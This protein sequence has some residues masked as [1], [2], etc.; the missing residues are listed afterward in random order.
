MIPSSSIS[1]EEAEGKAA[2]EAVKWAKALQLQ[3]VHFE[4]DAKVIINYLTTLS[5]SRQIEWRTKAHLDDIQALIPSFISVVYLF[6]PRG[7]NSVA[8]ALASRARAST[9]KVAS[10]DPPSFIF[11]MLSKN[12]DISLEAMA[13]LSI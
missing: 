5:L 6:V 13:S 8:D 1:T 9:S 10:T 7:V 4:G 2:L 11:D 3:Q 12:C